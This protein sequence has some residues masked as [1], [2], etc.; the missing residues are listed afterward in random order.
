MGERIVKTG[1][2]EVMGVLLSPEITNSLLYQ[3]LAGGITPYSQEVYRDHE[4][5]TTVRRNLRE[6]GVTEQDIE[7]HFGM[8]ADDKGAQRYLAEV[9]KGQMDLARRRSLK[10]AS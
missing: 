3:I 7:L 8:A 2:D 9:I 1:A 4:I 10:V 6:L 5:C